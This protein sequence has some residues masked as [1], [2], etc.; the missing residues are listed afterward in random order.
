MRRLTFAYLTGKN[1]SF[2]T[3]AGRSYIVLHTA[4]QDAF[5]RAVTVAPV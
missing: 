1:Y 4:N 2:V 5:N 3:S